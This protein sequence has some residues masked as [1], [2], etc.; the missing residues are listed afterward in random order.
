MR[1]IFVVNCIV[2][3]LAGFLLEGCTQGILSNMWRDPSY[4]GAPL[5]NFLVIAVR[6]D[7]VHRRMWEDGFVTEMNKYGCVTTPSY[8]LFPDALPD[9]AQCIAAIQENHFDG[10]L[11]TRRLGIDTSTLYLPGYTKDVP[12]TRYNRWTN[13]YHTYYRTEEVPAT[14]ETEKTVRHEAN[15]WVTGPEG[16]LV[17]SAVGGMLQNDG[18][19]SINHEIAELIVP[20][21][22]NQGI[23]P[24]KK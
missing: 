8:I 21:L 12:V 22:S 20:E 7:P 2:A 11:V 5:K 10:V 24:P 3:G 17:W 6:K 9:T 18:G 15:V 4:R 1:R 13:M 14:T 19:K 23:I 16:R